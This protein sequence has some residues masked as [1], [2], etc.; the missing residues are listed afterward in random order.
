MTFLVALILPIMALVCHVGLLI[1]VFSRGHGFI[2]AIEVAQ[3]SL[4]SRGI[5]GRDV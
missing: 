1:V 5:L 4:L 3:D 2:L